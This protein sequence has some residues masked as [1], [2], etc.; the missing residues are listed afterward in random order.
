MPYITPNDVHSPKAHWRLVKVLHDGGAGNGAYALGYWDDEPRIG[1]RWNGSDDNPI[2]NPQSRGLPTW[3][4]LEHSLYLPMIQTLPI[5]KQP[6]AC[7]F[8][9]IEVLPTI[10]FKVSV[11]PSGNHT[12][13]QR[14]AGQRMYEDVMKSGAFVNHDKALFFETLAKEVK[15]HLDAGSRVIL[16]NV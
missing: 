7:S 14:A 12:L 2:G 9:G 11:H 4:M 3:T 5:E 8:L 6:L 13:M 1:F 10:E 15:A 16:E